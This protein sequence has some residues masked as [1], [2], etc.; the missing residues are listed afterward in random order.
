MLEGDVLSD[1]EFHR[2]ALEIR[3]LINIL[4][5]MTKQ[6]LE[7]RLEAYSVDVGALPF[8]AMRLLSYQD[9]TISE[10]SRKMMLKP[11]TLVPVIDA[12]ERRGLVKRGQDPRDRRRTPV[13]LT[14]QGAEMLARVPAVDTNDAVLI[15]LRKMGIDKGDQLLALL[16]ELATDISEEGVVEEIAAVANSILRP[17]SE[18]IRS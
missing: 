7:K 11:A 18:S 3:I 4:A 9:S 15:S 12:L 8:S 2:R 10:L 14:E 1:D 16:R 5:K 6:E 13:S 17:R